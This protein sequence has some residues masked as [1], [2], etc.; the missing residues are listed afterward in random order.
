[1]QKPD[2]AGLGKL[3]AP[4]GAAIQSANVLTDN[5][6]SLIFNHNKVI[7]E[8]LQSL[9]WVIYSEPASGESCVGEACSILPMQY[10][11]GCIKRLEFGVEP[12][13]AIVAA[14]PSS[15]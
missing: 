14:M 4:V 12:P 7:A 13:N 11:A 15:C 10:T 8:A 1:M 5:R 3:V 6:R 2:D 9:S